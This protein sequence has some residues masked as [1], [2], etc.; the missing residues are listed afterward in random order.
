M[1]VTS[2]GICVTVHT[3]LS[4]RSHTYTAI[5]KG[6]KL[7]KD[8]CRICLGWNCGF[9]SVS[10]FNLLNTQENL[11]GKTVIYQGVCKEHPR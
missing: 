1:C 8:L 5:W 7:A 2:Y 3:S 10:P 9:A 6:V 11:F 4:A